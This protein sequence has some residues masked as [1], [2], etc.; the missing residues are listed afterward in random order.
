MGQA[1]QSSQH[2]CGLTELKQ[3][4]DCEKRPVEFSPRNKTLL[5]ETI[6]THCREWPMEKK[7]VQ[8]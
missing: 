4:R 6:G 7:L 1:E 3:I 2:V 5:L 8:N